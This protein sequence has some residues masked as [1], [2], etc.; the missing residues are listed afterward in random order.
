M[1]GIRGHGQ[2]LVLLAIES[3]GIEPELLV[4]EGL[5][6]PREQCGGLGA[7]LLCAIMLAE[8]FENLRHAHPRIVNVALKLASRLGSLPRRA[9]RMHDRI[10]G[11]LPAHILV[12]SRRARLIL[13]KS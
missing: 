12:P 2:N 13:L 8:R 4:P 9:I 1:P 5:V 10:A 3:K 6:E 7:Q 11:I